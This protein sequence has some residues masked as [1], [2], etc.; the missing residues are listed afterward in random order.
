VEIV[1]FIIH[2]VEHVLRT[3]FNA[4][5]SD[6][7]VHV[8]DPFTGTAT[9]ITRL[10]QSGL[11]RPADLQRK[12]THELHAN[13]I[14]LLAYYIAT[15]NI[16]ATFHGITGGDYLPFSGIVLADTF[17]ITEAGDTLD[18]VIFPDNNE[19]I[20]HQKTLDI[21]VVISNPPYSVGQ[22]S[23][24][25]GNANLVYPTLDE[26]IESTYAAKSSAGLK[27]NLYDSYV[28]AFRWASD[29]I[30]NQGVVCFVSNGSFIDGGFADGFRHTLAEEFTGIYVF[31]LRGNQ[32]TSGETSRREGGKIFGQGSRTPVAITLLVKNAAAPAGC[33]LRYCDIGDYLSREDKLAMIAKVGSI[34]TVPWQVLEPNAFGDWINQRNDLFESFTP[35]GAKKDETADPIFATYSLGVVTGRDAWAYNFSRAGMLAKMRRMVDSYTRQSVDFDTWLSQHGRPRNAAAVEDFIDRDPARISWTVNLK[36]DLRKGKPAV[37][38]AGRVVVGM[39]RSFSGK[40]DKLQVIGVAGFEAETQPG[41][42]PQAVQPMLAFPHVAEW[43]DAIYA[44]IVKKVGDRRY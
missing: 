44:K 8:L 20:A 18:E 35:L 24:N 31:N 2:S 25:D 13:E 37:F 16:E 11:I 29:R 27:R 41:T 1:D 28:R 36:E 21:R 6:L 22:S 23:Q 3:E 33:T 14:L 7:G 38:D 40:S 30:K 39:Y 5:I 9:F 17:Q 32:R 12:Y 43:R 26:A 42:G 4:S 15:I 10:L 19:R 34:E